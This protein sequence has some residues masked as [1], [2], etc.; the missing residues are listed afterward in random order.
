MGCSNSKAVP[1]VPP[2]QRSP[3]PEVA[4]NPLRP[5]EPQ[6]N[7][8]MAQSFKRPSKGGREGGGGG[9][10]GGGGKLK[11]NKASAFNAQKQA[12]KLPKRR[13]S[14]AKRGS[15]VLADM[16][17]T[18]LSEESP[19]KQSKSEEKKID[20]IA[21]QGLACRDIGEHEKALGYY[22]K[23]RNAYG[24][25]LGHEHRKTLNMAVFVANS[26][27]HLGK[28][29][30]AIAQLKVV[31]SKQEKAFGRDDENT[32][33]TLLSLANAYDDK[34]DHLEARKRY[35]TCLVRQSRKYGDAHPDTLMTLD[36]LGSLFQADFREFD[37]ALDMYERSLAGHEASLGAN[38]EETLK[39]A[40]NMAIV[41]DEGLRDY[42]KAEALY[43][44][45][46]DG[47]AETLGK[48]NA[49]TLDCAENYK[50]CLEDSG[51]QGSLEDLMR[52]YFPAA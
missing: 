30:D 12:E 51:R 33:S 25:L 13:M 7:N 45:A 16:L 8:N 26:N 9:R 47:F 48:E 4:S 22:V 2:S 10:G 52:E 23:A 5:S 38:H 29:D 32:L 34:Q 50:C 1:P 18:N 17:K 28:L 46:L 42:K 21:Q 39:T 44:R 11:P 49:L 3:P 31:L 14:V 40:M 43:K 15:D 35:E 36:N 20:V 19:Q 37:N 6:M 41:Y 24:K 27:A